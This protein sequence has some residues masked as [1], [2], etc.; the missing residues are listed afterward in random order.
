MFHAASLIFFPWPCMTISFIFRF[1]SANNEYFE[2]R[3][4]AVLCKK[5]FLILAIF[6]CSL[7]TFILAF[8]LFLLFFFFFDSLTCNFASLS[9]HFLRWWGFLI[10][11]LSERV[12]KFMRPMSIPVA[13]PAFFFGSVFPSSAENI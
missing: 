7:A 5:S 11:F 1:S 10:I 4:F 12:A 13:G 2:R 6:S 9:C 3:E 8:I